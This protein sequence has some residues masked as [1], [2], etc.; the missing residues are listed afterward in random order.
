MV[1]NLTSGSIVLD[2]TVVDYSFNN[3]DV[4][5]EAPLLLVNGTERNSSDFHHWHNGTSNGTLHHRPEVIYASVTL[6]VGLGKFLSE[7]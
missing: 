1:G 4:R 3:I 7:I 2:D 5:N 6:S